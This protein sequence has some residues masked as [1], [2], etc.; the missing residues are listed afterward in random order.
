[1]VAAPA[2]LPA[3][4]AEDGQVH[5]PRPSHGPIA[6]DVRSD[7]DEFIG[8]GLALVGLQA[9]ATP[10]AVVAAL[11]VLIDQ[12]QLGQFKLPK[13]KPAVMAAGCVFGEQLH[14]ALGYQWAQ[15]VDGVAG[16]GIEHR[17]RK[18]R[19]GKSN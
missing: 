5:G 1:M 11:H 7:M 3:R 12:V 14:R 4:F 6:A 2:Q 10:E 8:R 18:D 19:S 9:S 16:G 15:V 17:R 13:K